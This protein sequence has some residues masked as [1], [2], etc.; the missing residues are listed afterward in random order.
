[1]LDELRSELEEAAFMLVDDSDRKE[2]HSKLVK[3]LILLDKIKSGANQEDA[4]LERESSAEIAKVVRRLKM[5]SKP[6]RQSQF[7]SQI[8]NAYIE[9]KRSGL[10]KITEEDIHSHIGPNSWF[11]SNFIQMKVVAD[12]NHGKIFDSDGRYVTIW[13]PVQSAVHEYERVVFQSE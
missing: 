5:W 9:L 10:E 4:K 13:G 8:L 1:M 3:C 7:N 11:I 12:R 6:E 2:I